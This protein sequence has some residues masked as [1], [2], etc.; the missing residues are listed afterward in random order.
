[1]YN[2]ENYIRACI[3]SLLKQ[4]IEKEIILIDDGSTDSTYEIA[5]QYKLENPCITLLHQENAGQSV[6]RNRGVSMSRGEYIFFCDSDDCIDEESLPGLY[7]I[8]TENELDILKTGW[9]TQMDGKAYINL[10]KEGTIPFGVRMSSRDYFLQSIYKWYN[11]V[12]FDGMFRREFLRENKIVFPEGI[13]FEDNMYH[14]SSLLTKPDAKVMQVDST[15]YTAYIRE[16]STTMSK[17]KPKKIYDQLEN[18]RLMNGFIQNK[19]ADSKM[20]EIAKV[21]VSSLVF[22]M[23]SYYYRADRKYRKELSRAIPKKVLKDAIAHPQT[24]LQKY[25]L[26]AFTYVR[27]ILDCYEYFH[28]REAK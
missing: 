4:S 23:T 20:Q 3:E 21:A 24:K 10:P 1:M 9:K 27:P 5:E 25:K 14:F 17:P 11:V 13:Q 16:E 28:M 19:I 18:V 2:V 22:T 6:A 8:C 12:P 15:F 7:Q 26:V